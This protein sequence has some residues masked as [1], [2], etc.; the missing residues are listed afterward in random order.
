LGN[1]SQAPVLTVK[2]NTESDVP[3][4]SLSLSQMEKAWNEH[5]PFD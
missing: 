4:I 5:L 2:T 3:L 1:V